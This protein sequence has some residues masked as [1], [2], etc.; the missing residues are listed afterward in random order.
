MDGSL[1]REILEVLAAHG[2][3]SVPGI[4]DALDRHP[5]TVDRQCYDLQ[6]DGHIVIA[7]SGGAYKLTEEGRSRLERSDDEGV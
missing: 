2:Q 1:E 6:T 5:V 4:A 3:L 7:T